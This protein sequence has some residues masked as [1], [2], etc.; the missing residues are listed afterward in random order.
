LIATHSPILMAYPGA[1]ILSL[2]D[3]PIK[4]IAFDDIEHVKFMRNFLNDPENY[5]RR[6]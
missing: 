3:S 1:T 5:L 4:K 2:D 6:L